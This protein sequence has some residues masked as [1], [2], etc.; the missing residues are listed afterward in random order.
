MGQLSLDIERFYKE[1]SEKGQKVRGFF[2]LQY[3]IYCIHATIKDSTPDPL[4]NID[5]VIADFL[6]VKADFKHAQMASILGTSKALIE[7]RVNSMTE[8]NLLETIH[9]GYTL[10]SEGQAV[11][12]HKVKTRQHKRS[13]D[14]YIDGIT[15]SPLPKIFY[16]FY[17]SRFISENDFH[18]WT[19]PSGQTKIVKPFGPDLVHTPLDKKIVTDKVFAISNELREAYS[20]PSGIEGIE[21]LSFTKLTLQLLVGVSTKGVSIVKEL[22]DGFAFYSLGEGISYYEAT[23]RNI[24]IFENELKSKLEKLE[25]K[26]DV[27][28]QRN[29]SE[30]APKAQLVTNWPEIDRYEN[31]QNRCFSFSIED[32]AILIEQKFHVKVSSEY[33][34]NSDNNIEVNIDKTALLESTDRLKL[35][36][37]LIRKRDYRFGTLESNVYLIYLYFSTADPFVQKVIE[38]KK[39]I[40]QFVEAN[41][42]VSAKLI[43]EKHPEYS[44]NYRELLIAA[45]EYEILE[46]IDITNYMS[47]IN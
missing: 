39:S 10:S 14:F 44:S 2:S 32:L 11:F 35:V 30:E 41:V 18:Y 3:P 8:D 38:F 25:F 42:R 15:F 31:S 23:K 21:D 45:A 19:N 16:S 33:I 12:E 7:M 22:V 36:N 46:N 40:N 1:M 5:R 29:P 34:T 26:I 6:K 4:D 37:N 20:I 43:F 28:K 27:P 13:Y 9:E 24:R 17:R 47:T